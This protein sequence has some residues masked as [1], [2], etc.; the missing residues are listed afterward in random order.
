MTEERTQGLFLL[1]NL[2]NLNYL[3]LILL[4]IQNNR[5]YKEQVTLS[6]F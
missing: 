4:F 6:R 2:K 3:F 5:I 1:T